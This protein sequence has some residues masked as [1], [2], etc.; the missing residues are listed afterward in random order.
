[1]INYLSFR[2]SFVTKYVVIKEK[3]DV[4]KSFSVWRNSVF[5]VHTHWVELQAKYEVY[6]NNTKNKTNLASKYIIPLTFKKKYS[7]IR[8]E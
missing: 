6:V 8:S 5:K 4:E 2:W 1:M 3:L 7:Q